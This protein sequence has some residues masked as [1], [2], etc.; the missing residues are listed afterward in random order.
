M[1]FLIFFIQN[2]FTILRRNYILNT[3]RNQLN[4]YP[5]FNFRPVIIFNLEKPSPNF[6]APSANIPLQLINWKFQ[7]RFLFFLFKTILHF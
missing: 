1:S 2:N 4:F 5:K 3:P 7:Y 6:A